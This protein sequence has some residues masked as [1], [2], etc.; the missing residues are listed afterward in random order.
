MESSTSHVQ[1]DTLRPFQFWK[2]VYLL[3]TTALKAASLPELLTGVTL[4]PTLSIFYHLHHHYFSHPELLP[5]Y[6]NEFAQWVA[7]ELGNSVV[8]ECL[9][10]LNLFRATNLATAVSQG[11]LALHHCFS[12]HATFV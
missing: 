11:N 6:P 4:A 3:E 8:A 12:T 1:R 10:N 7:T 9:A 2:A 5:E